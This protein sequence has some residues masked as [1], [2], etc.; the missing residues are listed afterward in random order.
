MVKDT[1]RNLLNSQSKLCIQRDKFVRIKSNNANLHYTMQKKL[2][3]GSY[4]SVYRVMCKASRQLRAMKI[5]KKAD[6][7]NEENVFAE[8][9]TLRQLDHPNI[10]KLYE[11][12][13]D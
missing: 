3:E 5:I 1:P 8:L 6:V 10:L 9:E 13:E 12:L 2:G 7:T 11:V 4:G